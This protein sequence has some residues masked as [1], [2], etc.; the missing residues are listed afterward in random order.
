MSQRDAKLIGGVYRVAQVLTA[1][2]LCTHCTAYNHNTNDVVGLFIV[3][4]PPII[5]PRMAQQL[6]QPLQQRQAVRSRHILHVHDWGVDGSRVYIATDP[7]RGVT[8]RHVLDN[9]NIDLQ[10]TVDLSRQIVQGLKTLHERGI[11]GIDLRPQLVTIDT[12]GVTDRVQLDD[13]GLR[14]LLS[15][16]GAMNSHQNNDVGSLDPRYAPP[17]YIIGGHVGPWSDTY[18]VGL[19]LFEMTTGRLPFVGQNTAETGIMQSNNPAPRM[20][21]FKYDTSLALQEV[22]E[23]AL[24]KD[25]AQRFNSADA[26]LSALDSVPIPRLPSHELRSTQGMAVVRPGI[27]ATTEMP[28]LPHEVPFPPSLMVQATTE[29][30]VPVHSVPSSEGVYAYLCLEQDGIETQRLSVTQANVVIGRIDPK[31]GFS[32]DIDISKLDLRMTVSRQHARIRFEENFFY[33]EDL[34]SRNKT[35]LGGLILTPLHAELLQHNDMLRFGSVQL[36]FKVVGMT[37]APV[38]KG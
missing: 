5:H 31:N 1:T 9:E 7:P 8:L 13:V 26:L 21:N 11:A 38:R 27:G 32:P 17:E 20:T 4:V 33:I 23:R 15:G 6:L 12:I 28:P 35:R 14:V 16:L 3:E 19:L 34:K 25:P 10:R 24:A 30:N 29:K 18:Q 37:D 2:G 36:I 22:V